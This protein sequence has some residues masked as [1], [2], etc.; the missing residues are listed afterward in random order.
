MTPDQTSSSVRRQTTEKCAEKKSVATAKS[1]RRSIE[2]EMDSKK[3][4]NKQETHMTE[5]SAKDS[6]RT[7][8]DQSAVKPK[9]SDTKTNPCENVCVVDTNAE[10]SMDVSDK[11]KKTVKQRDSDKV[12]ASQVDEKCVSKSQDSVN[13]KVTNIKM[14]CAVSETKSEKSG[15]ELCEKSKRQSNGKQGSLEKDHVLPESK[16]K[17]N[18]SSPEVSK[19]DSPNPVSNNKGNK[20]KGKKKSKQ[21]DAMASS[22]FV[23][24]VVKY[25]EDSLK[26]KDIVDDVSDSTKSE[27]LEGKSSLDDVNDPTETDECAKNIPTEK[28]N[29]DGIHDSPIKCKLGNDVNNAKARPLSDKTEELSVNVALDV[30]NVTSR[31]KVQKSDDGVKI[32]E[33]KKDQV[34]EEVAVA[35]PPFADNND[36]QDTSNKTGDE[37]EMKMSKQ[38]KKKSKNEEAVKQQQ[39]SEDKRESIMD[40]KSKENTISDDQKAKRDTKK[41]SDDDNVETTVLEPEVEAV[42]VPTGPTATE[43]KQV[44]PSFNSGM[45]KNKKMKT[46]EAEIIDIQFEKNTFSAVAS[47]KKKRNGKSQMSDFTFHVEMDDKDKS[48]EAVAVAITETG[49]F[50]VETQETETFTLESHDE[51]FV[52]ETK[53]TESFSLDDAEESPIIEDIVEETQDEELTYEITMLDLDDEKRENQDDSLTGVNDSN[54]KLLTLKH[55][56]KDQEKSKKKK[57]GENQEKSLTE[58]SQSVSPAEIG[59]QLDE[60][61]EKTE[62]NND[63]VEPSSK[64]ISEGVGSNTKMDEALV[65]KKKKK[66]KQTSKT[67]DVLPQEEMQENST[68]VSEETSF[69]VKA[70]S[71][72]ALDYGIRIEENTD[73]KIEKS[74]IDVSPSDGTD[75]LEEKAYVSKDM[76][77]KMIDTVKRDAKSKSDVLG[78]VNNSEE[79]NGKKKKRKKK[80]NMQASMYEV[81]EDVDK[82]KEQES[83]TTQEKTAGSLNI[84]IAESK[85]QHKAMA[86]SVLV[87]EDTIKTSP[88]V[89]NLSKEGMDSIEDL[90]CIYKKKKNKKTK[91]ADKTEEEELS[92]VVEK[93]AENDTVNDKTEI[94]RDKPDQKVRVEVKPTEIE[95]KLD[96]MKTTEA[97]NEKDKKNEWKITR[98]GSS[99]KEMSDSLEKDDDFALA[100]EH[101]RSFDSECDSKYET[102]DD[103]PAAWEKAGTEDSVSYEKEHVT[104]SSS[105]GSDVGQSKHF[106]IPDTESNASKLTLVDSKSEIETDLPV[107]DDKIVKD[108]IGKAPGLD[109]KGDTVEASGE[110][111][112]G[113]NRSSEEKEVPTTAKGDTKSSESKSKKKKKKNRK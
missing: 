86:K 66:S 20:K 56:G 57:N 96:S 104:R 17:R 42:A 87:S 77:S 75:L 98:D 3:M 58:V 99:D 18:S 23:D 71:E 25:D 79:G 65:K 39:S 43:D 51:S 61:F 22:V 108:V 93:A 109:L 9:L 95:I 69:N 2:K 1:S 63:L 16:C 70:T 13:K 97:V 35:K 53:E 62:R 6:E 113:S 28:T 8:T 55:K 24:S 32:E 47:K 30:E 45:S 110:S 10:K 92:L 59:D 90:S 111:S 36:P 100:R 89:E 73:L 80:G 5:E 105:E 82:A 54:E 94:I 107:E 78:G 112:S 19:S 60:A 38:K 34:A 84:E 68:E 11:S 74:P 103:D 85:S 40:R 76:P 15:Q 81:F 106:K 44:W 26:A 52:F 14:D 102:A 7:V 41:K 67:V 64:K 29:K 12:K 21:S 88:E 91:Q 101:G 83:K 4:D 37:I 27:G 33:G 49:S 31:S 72:S 46:E 50:T 48:E